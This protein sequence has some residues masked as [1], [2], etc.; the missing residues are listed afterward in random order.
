MVNSQHSQARR[1]TKLLLLRV[2]SQPCLGYKCGSKICLDGLRFQA[3]F[4]YKLGR[5]GTYFFKQTLTT[6]FDGV[7]VCFLHTLSVH[8]WNILLTQVV[9]LGTHPWCCTNDEPILKFVQNE[10]LTAPRRASASPGLAVYF[11]TRADAECQMT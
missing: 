6:Y 3:T 10:I 4:R 7:K 11:P 1:D 2:G 5:Y 9:V 8:T